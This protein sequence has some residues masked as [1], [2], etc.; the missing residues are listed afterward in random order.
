VIERRDEDARALASTGCT[1]AHLDFPDSQFWAW[2]DPL[3]SLE[4]AEALRPYLG[5]ADDVYIPA[6]I[7]N[8][9]HKLVR[10]AALAIRPDA[11]FYADLPYTA[12]PDLGGFHLPPDTAAADRRRRDVKLD[13][14]SV[15][16]KLEA[17]RCYS[18]QLRQLT[19]TFGPVLNP[20]SL[21]LEVFWLSA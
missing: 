17:S 6:G 8:P 15:T 7:H 9:D 10:D 11:I 3:R 20:D 16:A 5:R 21:G 12:H 4:L 14:Q 19:E 18:T 2:L 13:D 1:V